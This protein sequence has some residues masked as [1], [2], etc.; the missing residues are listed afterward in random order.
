MIM[1][2]Y[3]MSEELEKKVSASE[4]KICEG[5]SNYT[6]P[7]HV[8]CRKCVMF[9]N[10]DPVDN[11]P[12]E[13]KLKEY[14]SELQGLINAMDSCYRDNPIIRDRCATLTMVVDR[15]K[16]IIGMEE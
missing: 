13:N 3:T 6:K 1:T 8:A 5:C 2:D 14:I 4:R 15:L 11:K 7:T 12:L 16:G 9:S 10:Y